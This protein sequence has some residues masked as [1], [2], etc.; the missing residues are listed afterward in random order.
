MAKARAIV[1]PFMS[2]HPQTEGHV[3]L[4]TLAIGSL[5][6]VLAAGFGALQLMERADAWI[7]RLL[8]SGGLGVATKSLPLWCVWLAAAIGAFG[9][10]VSI[11]CVAGNWRRILLWVSTLVV[12]AGWAPVLAIASHAPDVS[13]PLLV[14]FWSGL[15][16]FIYAARHHM[17]ADDE[18]D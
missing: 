6:L 2:K 16:A 9:L 14:T 3:L 18:K 17:P 10:S 7:A 8:E 15:C 13:I 12:V 11:L 4:P 1:R 5:A